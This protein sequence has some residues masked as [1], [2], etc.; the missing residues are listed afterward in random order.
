MLAITTSKTMETILGIDIGATGIKGALVNVMT[1]ELVTDRIKYPTPKPALP[2]TMVATAAQIVKDLEWQ[3]KPIGIGFPAIIKRGVTWSASNID[4]TWI[5]HKAKAVFA[6]AFE[7][8][9][10]VILNDADAAGLAEMSHGIGLDRMGVILLVTLGTGIGSAL[11]NNGQLVPNT[12]LGHL[13]YKHGVYEDYASNGARERRDLSW[14]EWGRELN[15]YLNHIDFLFSPDLIIIG[16]GVS[17]KYDKYQKYLSVDTEVAPA[18]LRNNAGI[19]GAAM[20]MHK[21]MV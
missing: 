6:A 21:T 2:H 20:A 16:G 4:D 11:F 15:S 9:Q 1:G 14:K 12:E 7:T 8:E 10:L 18:H 19:V 5:G 3:G 13:K 17:K